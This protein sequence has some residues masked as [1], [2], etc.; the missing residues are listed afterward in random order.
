[1]RSRNCRPR[2]VYFFAI[3]ITR[4][5][6]ASIISRLARRALASPVDIWRAISF[7]SL[8][9]MPT[10]FCRL[11]SDS[12]CSITAGLKRSSALA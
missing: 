8:I 12:C 11:M 3:E 6:L 7:R 9:G 2:L 1:M 10:S 4:R 5:R